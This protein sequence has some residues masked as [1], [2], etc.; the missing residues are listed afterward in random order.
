MPIALND[1]RLEW[2]RQKV[3]CPESVKDKKKLYI[4]TDRAHEKFGQYFQYIP[5]GQ[6]PSGKVIFDVKYHGE[7]L[8]AAKKSELS[9]Q[10]QDFLRTLP[11]RARGRQSNPGKNET[12]YE[13]DEEAD[14]LEPGNVIAVPVVL[15]AKVVRRAVYMAFFVISSSVHCADKECSIV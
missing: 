7:P 10:Y 11:Q 5:K 1:E 9:R 15:Y 14:C 3:P 12:A 13:D 2:L 6:L 4:N 8:D